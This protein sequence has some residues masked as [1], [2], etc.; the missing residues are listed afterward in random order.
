MPA[1]GG[2]GFPSHQSGKRTDASE[3]GPPP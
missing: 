1:K 3:K 2:L